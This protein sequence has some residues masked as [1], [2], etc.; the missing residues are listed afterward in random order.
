MQPIDGTLL[1][2]NIGKSVAPDEKGDQHKRSQYEK[3]KKQ[4][5]LARII[6]LNISR[7]H[8]CTSLVCDLPDHEALENFESRIIFLMDNG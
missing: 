3:E 6:Y 2:K 5:H 8:Q 7:M 1:R 4:P